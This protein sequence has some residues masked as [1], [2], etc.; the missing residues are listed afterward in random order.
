MFIWTT[1]KIH[2][3]QQA[4]NYTKYYKEI[5][6]DISPYIKKTDH[7]CDLGCGLGDLSIEI[8]SIANKVTS[9]DISKDALNVLQQKITHQHIENI[10]LLQSNWSDLSLTPQWDVVIVSFFRQ[11]YEDFI[12]LLK[13]ARQKII[14]VATNGSE[15]SF[16]P[17]QK[18][19]RN[20]G[21]IDDLKATFTEHGLHF[22]CIERTVEFGQP[23]ASVDDAR[24]YIKQYVP[25]CDHDTMEAH[26]EERLLKIED[27]DFAGQYFFPN[28]KEIGIFIIEKD[29]AVN[30]LPELQ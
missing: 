5:F 25:A 28:K 2:W 18:K 11:N 17:R 15:D 14:V 4:A 30:K 8:A 13:M 7:V 27:G 24:A 6:R 20:K 26:I 16:L 3:Y 23:L 12:K 9:I 10:E 1:E 19:H 29:E 21:K 22:N